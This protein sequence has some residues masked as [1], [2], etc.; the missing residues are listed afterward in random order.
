[1]D[2]NI[3]AVIGFC[4]AISPCVIFLI[5]NLCCNSDNNH[6]RND[7]VRIYTEGHLLMGN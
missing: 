6:S 5:Y 1:M 4:S 2:Q 7:R 3:L